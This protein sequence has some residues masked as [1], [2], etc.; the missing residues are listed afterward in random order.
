MSASPD[1]RERLTGPVLE[2]APRLLDAVLRHGEVAVRLTEVEAYAGPDDP[3]S[4]AYRGH[5]PPQ[6][7]DVRAARPPVLLLHLRHARLLQRHRRPRGERRARCCSG[8]GR[9]SSGVDEVRGAPV[10]VPRPRSR[11]RPG[12]A[13]PG[14]RDRADR[15]RH[16]PR[17]RARS[18]S[19][20][21]TAPDEVATR[22]PGRPAG[23]P[24]PPV[25]VL[26]RGGS[27]R[28]RRTAVTGSRH[29]P[30]S[31]DWQSRTTALLAFPT[32]RWRPPQPRPPGR[33]GGGFAAPR[34]RHGRPRRP[35]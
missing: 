9:W 33:I 23:R 12:P 31:P 26:D 10:A 3:G 21:A 17:L 20:S 15:Q 32:S 8:P 11:P 4:H 7:G 1:L 14:A 29:R 5:D 27:A 16:R 18:R 35:S 34:H 25:A 2:V 13:L 24:R 28:S 30:M 6:R 22:S 19:S